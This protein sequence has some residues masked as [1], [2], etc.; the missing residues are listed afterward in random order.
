MDLKAEHFERQVHTL[1]QDRDGWEKKYEVSQIDRRSFIPHSPLSTG[2]PREVSGLQEG[3]RRACR[4][5]GR[6]MIALRSLFSRL[7]VWHRARDKY[8][9]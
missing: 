3:A 8:R 4:Q 7:Y 2:R 1:E 6:T 5:H 9:A